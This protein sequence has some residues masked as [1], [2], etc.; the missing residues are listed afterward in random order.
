MR[1]RNFTEQRKPVSFAAFLAALLLLAV[2]GA[3]C[4]GWG[5]GHNSSTAAAIQV[6]PKW[7]QDILEEE[8]EEL[9]K[10][11]CHY[12]DTYGGDKEAIGPYLYIQ[13][14]VPFHYFPEEPIEKHFERCMNGFTFIF[15]NASRAIRENRVTDAAKFLGGA[16][17]V[18][19][20]GSMQHGIEG[21]YGLRRPGWATG[22]P[23][24]NQL[25]PVP[26]SKKNRPVG[27]YHS[28]TLP[29]PGAQRNA[30]IPGYKPLLLGTTPKEA[31]FHMY[32]R[33]WD[34]LL[35][36]RRGDARIMRWFYADDMKG[37]LKE[38]DIML[39]N[40]SSI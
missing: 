7:A 36:A 22:Y 30:W 32:K 40:T 38:L 4:F 25:F 31:A 19:D 2:S 29:V 6:L 33:F 28:G 26:P 34:M 5:Y 27:M 35:G 10:H 37:F 9:I 16:H 23:M 11:Y 12:C 17:V 1:M 21:I 18:Q 8:R 14:G 13:R 15:E 24:L 39:K 3:P 20:N